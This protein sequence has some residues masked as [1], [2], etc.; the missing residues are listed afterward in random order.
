MWPII[1]VNTIPSPIISTKNGGIIRTSHGV[2]TLMCKNHPPVSNLK[3]ISQTWKKFSPNLCKRLT[4]L[5]MILKA[6]FRSQGASI[7]NLEHQVGE[8]SKL[9]TEI[10]QG[11]LPSITKTDPKDHVKTITLRSG[12]E[13]EQSKETEQQANKEDTSIPK[14]QDAST[15]IQPSIPKPSS[16][17]IPFPQRLK[18]Q[19]LDKQFSKFIDIFKSL[20]I[21][22]PFVDMLEQISKYA[23]FLKEVLSN[24]RKLMDSEKVMFTEECNAILQRK[25][26]PKLK[27]PRNFT[28]HCTIGDFDFDKDLCDLGTSV[29]LM[30]LSIFWKLGLGEVKPTTMCDASDFAIG[31]KVIIYIDHSTLRYLFAKKEA[32]PRLLS[33]ILLLQEF[34]LEIKDKKGTENLVADHLSRMNHVKPNEGV[35]DDI[36][37]RF[38]D[39]QLFTV[40]EALWYAD[41]VNYL[42]KKIF[43]SRAY[44]SKEEEVF[45]R[46]QMSR[47]GN[48]SRKNEMPLTNILQIE[49]FDVWGIDFMGPF[50]SSYA[51]RFISVVVDYVS[52]WVEAKALQTND[53]R[54]VVKFLKKN[55]FAR[56][57]TPR[58]I[59]SDGGSHFCNSQFESLL[60]KYGVTHRISTP[61]H[62]QT[63]GQV[64]VC[65]H[66]L[67]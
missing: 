41:I 40:E 18:K 38:P 24:K 27:D 53:A 36:N 47:V 6:N 28:I 39:E 60:G 14:E 22:L 16:N 49:L 48:I 12:E 35:D 13:L 56:F 5:L 58:A 50:P 51:N 4:I 52:K 65:N 66:E 19:N 54:V 30:P 31:S 59:I 23:K 26:P 9:L 3:R 43:A 34:D 29:N 44:L 21:N 11:A 67:K 1:N 7:R 45:L 46:S 42:A 55:I 37:E 2:T 33:W 25:L 64:E 20:H 32:K 10:T 17:A 61:Y 15:P 8:I 57:G 62:P 63:N